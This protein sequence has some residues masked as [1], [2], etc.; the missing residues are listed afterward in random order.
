V[1]ARRAL[2]LTA[3]T[4]LLTTVP[5]L[6]WGAP[7]QLASE[8][9]TGAQLASPSLYPSA[10]SSTDDKGGGKG[11]VDAGDSTT[12]VLGGRLDPSSV[13]SSWTATTAA[14]T[15]TGLTVTLTD[16]GSANDVLVVTTAAT[17]GCTAGLRLGTV[18]TGHPG[19]VTGGS[20]SFG[21]S[22]ATLTWSTT[23]STVVVVFGTR[24]GPLA[25]PGAASVLTWTPHPATRDSSGLAIARGTALS[26][27]TVQW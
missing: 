3:L 7:L 6:G 16:G 24:T 19:F 13:C 22:T 17:A 9:L 1:S 2:V 4:A 5:A 15:A 8:R 20:V 10:V 25:N 18:D 27:S 26:A 12:L 21:G 14:Q 23:S 11:K